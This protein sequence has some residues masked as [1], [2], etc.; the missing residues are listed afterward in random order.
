MLLKIGF[1]RIMLPPSI[2]GK[3]RVSFKKMLTRVPPKID[4]M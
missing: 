1:G 4:M 3:I 2:I